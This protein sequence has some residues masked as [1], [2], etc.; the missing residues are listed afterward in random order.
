MFETRSRRKFDARSRRARVARQRERKRAAALDRKLAELREIEET[1]IQLLGE[2]IAAYVDGLRPGPRGWKGIAG[3]ESVVL[4]PPDMF[5]AT[6]VQACGFYP[7]IVGAGTPMVGVPMGRHLITGATVCADPISWFQRARLIRNPSLYVLALNGTGKS[8]YVKHTATGLAAYGTI[9]IATADLKPDYVDMVRELGGQ[10]ISLGPGRGHLNILDPGE[11]HGAAALLRENGFEQKARE[12]LEDAHDRRKTM[13]SSLIT[14]QRKDEPTEREEMVLDAALRYLDSHF[15]GIPIL[16][17]LLRVVRE[18]P[19]E[20]R[21]AA[22]DGGNRARY[23]ELTETLEVSLSGLISGGRLGGIFA[24]HT[25][26]PMK[27][28]RAVVYDVSSIGE[29]NMDLQ[30]AVLMACWSQSFGMI[31]IAHVL[32]DVGIEP[33]RH[34]FAI[35][36]ELWRALRAGRG[37]VDRMDALTRLNRTLGTA[38]AYVTH[39]LKDND[40]L[41]NEEDRKKARGFIERAGYVV[42]GGLPGTEMPE[43]NQ[44]IPLSNAEQ[45]LLKSWQIPEEWD[46]H[47]GQ[48][49]EA[50]GIGKFLIKIAG[51]PGI[52]LKVGLTPIEKD[53]TNTDQRWGSQSRIGDRT[54][55]CAA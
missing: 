8:S 49:A 22:L 38:M 15:D 40:S 36:D 46:P 18:A 45:E 19:Q 21:D 35:V 24:Q 4:Q 41:A 53:P 6:T 2:E 17:D 29:D 14:I 31:N 3:G 43:L 50:P 39:T 27:R 16:A 52:P 30:A 12:V 37:M 33:R 25:S 13:L 11:A 26:E 51:K 55:V 1:A 42:L 44:V 47:T 10:V 7:F 48:A 32:A 34:Y 23:R 28:D 9:P 54:E 5:R 20:L